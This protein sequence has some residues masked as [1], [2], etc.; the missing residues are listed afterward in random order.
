MLEK[1]VHFEPKEA[2][3]AKEKGLEFYRRLAAELPPFLHSGAKL[4]F[5][6]GHRQGSDVLE[7]FHQTHWKQKRCEKDWA[8]NDRFFFLEFSPELP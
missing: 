8:G 7:I 3:I 1:E 5:E 4:F 2:H 6:I